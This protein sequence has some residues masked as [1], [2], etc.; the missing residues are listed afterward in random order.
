M[1]VHAHRCNILESKKPVLP[2]GDLIM[3]D[4][5]QQRIVKTGANVLF[6]SASKIICH[7]ENAFALAR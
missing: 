4:D 7:H 2:I 6:R 3:T 5:W 1:R